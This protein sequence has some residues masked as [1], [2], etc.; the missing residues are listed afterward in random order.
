MSRHA[1][2]VRVAGVCL[3][4]GCASTSRQYEFSQQR[5]VGNIEVLSAHKEVTFVIAGGNGGYTAI[6]PIGGGWPDRVC[7]R[8]QSSSLLDCEIRN[9][10]MRIHH[11]LGNGYTG[12]PQFVLHAEDNGAHWQTIKKPEYWMPIQKEAGTVKVGI[13]PIMYRHTT[14]TLW[15]NWTFRGEK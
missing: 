11:G 13:P 14:D 6:K 10:K 12:W 9:S 15:I 4:V 3:L 2:V 1:V 8:F 7:L 5:S